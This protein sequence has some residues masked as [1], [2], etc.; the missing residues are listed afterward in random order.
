MDPY[1]SSAS[2]EAQGPPPRPAPMARNAASSAVVAFGVRR[3]APWR[4]VFV[5]DGRLSRSGELWRSQL[6]RTVVTDRGDDQLI[7]VERTRGS[8]T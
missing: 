1:G 5:H 3:V 7:V 2:I 6:E 4:A 8:T